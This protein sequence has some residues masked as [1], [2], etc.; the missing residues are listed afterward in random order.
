MKIRSFEYVN[1]IEKRQNTETEA[2]T[3]TGTEIQDNGNTEIQSQQDGTPSQTTSKTKKSK[4]KT[5]SIQEQPV[6]TQQGLAQPTQVQPDQTQPEQ[7][8][9]QS[10][11]VNTPQPTEIQEGNQNPN[12]STNPQIADPGLFSNYNSTYGNSTGIDNA[13]YY[14]TSESLSRIQLKANKG[15]Y[16]VFFIVLGVFILFV[17]SF[18]LILQRMNKKKHEENK[19]DKYKRQSIYQQNLSRGIGTS[20]STN[21]ARLSRIIYDNN[22]PV[23]TP[24]IVSDFSFV[25]NGTDN[26]GNER[27]PRSSYYS[28]ANPQSQYRQSV[29]SVDASFYSNTYQTN[30]TNVATIVSSPNST[31]FN[32]RSAPHNRLSLQVSSTLVSPSSNYPNAN[33]FNIPSPTAA[34]TV[35]SITNS[36]PLVPPQD[37]ETEQYDS[38]EQ[39]PIKPLP[40][41]VSNPSS[42]PSTRV[43]KRPSRT[44]SI[45]PIPS[46]RPSRTSSIQLNTSSDQPLPSSPLPSPRPSRT[47][48]I[49]LNTS[50]EQPI[51]NSRPNR[52]SSIQNSP[53]SEKSFLSS[54]QSRTSSIQLNSNSEQSISISSPKYSHSPLA[55]VFEQEQE[56]SEENNTTTITETDTDSDTDT[57]SESESESE[58]ESDIDSNTNTN[59]TNNGNNGN[60]YENDDDD[61]DGSSS[62]SYDETTTQDISSSQDISYS[63]SYSQDVTHLTIDSHLK[64]KL[65]LNINININQDQDQ[66]Q[67]NVDITDRPLLSPRS[68]SLYSGQYTTNVSKRGDSFI[69][70][71]GLLSPK[72]EDSFLANQSINSIKESIL[73][74]DPSFDQEHDTSNILRS[75][76]PILPE[77][78]ENSIINITP[79]VPEIVAMSSSE[80]SN[81]HPSHS[82]TVTSESSTNPLMITKERRSSL[83]PLLKKE[84]SRNGNREDVRRSVSL[85]QSNFGSPI[86]KNNSVSSNNDGLESNVTI[87]GK[88]KDLM[89]EEKQEE[90]IDSKSSSINK[91]DSL[92]ININSHE[93]EGKSL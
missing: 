70:N 56:E 27:N 8:Q 14:E 38:Q 5:S 66:D 31:Q 53:T 79:M 87:K 25:N 60:N 90:K 41:P 9:I 23:L 65:D 52:S 33:P 30:P 43:S 37:S 17:I 3:G 35:E 22:S 20:S 85:Q 88:E 6:Q 84:D 77:I 18:I 93:P 54:R 82:L 16:T 64:P 80:D 62:S 91:N 19:T 71:R 48:S 69:L 29:Q 63:Q 57:D 34:A 2:G 72:R 44:S 75:V 49:Q 59:T 15:F 24:D 32:T 46:P 50:S 39:I 67:S 47:S 4:T 12:N 83:P 21:L 61:D 28:T 42:T 86:T 1:I 11:P 55:P 68:D 76:T 92:S 13:S 73:S 40:S 81:S 89:T 26:N 51:L 78:V 36:P 45:Q 10:S 58:S 74:R 7:T